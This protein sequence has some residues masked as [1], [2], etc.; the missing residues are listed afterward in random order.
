M[1]YDGS[2]KLVQPRAKEKLVTEVRKVLPEGDIADLGL[3]LR[4]AA[5]QNDLKVV[6]LLIEYGVDVNAAG[7][8]SGK[9]AY[10]RA[11][12]KGHEQCALILRKAAE[13]KG[14]FGVEVNGVNPKMPSIV[15]K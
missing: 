5:Y 4:K 8:G 9:T 15:K 13:E 12:E 3:A 14:K 7:P 1:S 2:I 6:C 10:D 11:L